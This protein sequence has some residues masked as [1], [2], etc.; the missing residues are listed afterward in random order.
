[1][2]DRKEVRT[3]AEYNAA[4]KRISEI[5]D[6]YPDDMAVPDSEMAEVRELFDRIEEYEIRNFSGERY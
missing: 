6:A 5:L 4:I 1:M 2:S 3:E